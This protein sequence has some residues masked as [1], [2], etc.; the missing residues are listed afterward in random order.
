MNIHKRYI[1]AWG[2]LALAILERAK[3]DNDTDFLKSDWADFLQEFVYVCGRS[4][5]TAYRYKNHL[6][7][8]KKKE[9][10]SNATIYK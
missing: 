10:N 1:N 9:V 4:T 2:A 3:K 5:A 8:N 6:E 7:L